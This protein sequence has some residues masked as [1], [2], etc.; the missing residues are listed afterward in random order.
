M[1]AQKLE[2]VMNQFS[3]KFRLLHED[4]LMAFII[5]L[6]QPSNYPNPYHWPTFSG[7][8]IYFFVKVFIPLLTDEH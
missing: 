6:T 8:I 3:Q 5:S 1:V 2:P 4:T 7:F